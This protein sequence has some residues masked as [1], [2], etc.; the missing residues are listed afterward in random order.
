MFRNSSE[1]LRKRAYTELNL[2]TRGERESWLQHPCTRS[3]L[4]TLDADSMDITEAWSNG[5]YTAESKDGTMQ[6]NAEALGHFKAVS[7]ILDFVEGIN[8]EEMFEDD[9]T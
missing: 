5:N 2:A 9:N 1:D 6:L 8:D 7:S 3:L 4:H